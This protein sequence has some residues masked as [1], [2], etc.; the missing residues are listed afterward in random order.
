[1]GLGS[2]S[3]KEHVFILFVNP[4]R[5]ERIL[6]KAF[7]M[8]ELWVFFSSSSVR[9]QNSHKTFTSQKELCEHCILHECAASVCSCLNKVQKKSLLWHLFENYTQNIYNG[10]IWMGICLF[11]F[12]FF[13]HISYTQVS[14]IHYYLIGLSNRCN[15]ILYWLKAIVR[16]INQFGYAAFPHP[17]HHDSSSATP[18]ILACG[19]SLDM[20]VL[21]RQK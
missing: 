1:M 2:G 4:F 8:S 15:I 12:F 21:H 17:C 13:V 19:V 14:K 7:Y 16:I 9:V 6:D 3:V 20:D 11:F 10:Q 18:L 5:N